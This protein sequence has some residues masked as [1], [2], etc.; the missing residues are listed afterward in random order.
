MGNYVNSPT[1][2]LKQDGEDNRQ[3]RDRP[4]TPA[5]DGT[6]LPC[7]GRARIG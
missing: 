1:P 7:R 2:N 3:S 6:C 5:A 4:R